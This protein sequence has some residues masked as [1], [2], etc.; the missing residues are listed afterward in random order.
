MAVRRVDPFKAGWF[1]SVIVSAPLAD[2]SR[3]KAM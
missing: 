1:G 2:L 3:R